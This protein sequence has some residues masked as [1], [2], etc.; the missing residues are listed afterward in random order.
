M[1][2]ALV[3]A[4]AA[5]GLVVGL[6]A[7]QKVTKSVSSSISPCF[8][9]LPLAQEAVGKQGTIVDI[10]RLRGG[11]VTVFD[12]ALRGEAAPELPPSSL[13]PPSSEPGTAPNPVSGRR[14]VCIVAFRGTFDPSRVQ[15]PLRPGTG[16]YAIVVVGSL[17]QRVRLVVLTDQ[18]PPPLHAHRG[19]PS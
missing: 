10:A 18:L 3:A 13:A 8:R 17:T 9:V 4:F 15:H 16:R 1:K 12:R 7:C 6:S 2:R 19:L 14:D 5:L 11:P